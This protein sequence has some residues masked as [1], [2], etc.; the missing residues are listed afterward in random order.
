VTYSKLLS[1]NFPGGTEK[2]YGNPFS[3]KPIH[4]LKS[5][6]RA[7]RILNR[8]AN[9]WAATFGIWQSI[10]CIPNIQGAQMTGLILC[11]NEKTAGTFCTT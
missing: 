9:H 3:V 10:N 8:R 6:P 2:N 1:R 5:E 7:S 4:G 11:S